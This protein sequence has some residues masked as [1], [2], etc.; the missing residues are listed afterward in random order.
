MQGMQNHK[1]KRE[2]QEMEEKIH[3]FVRRQVDLLVEL[4][5]VWGTQIKGTREARSSITKGD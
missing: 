5:T 2:V 4:S 1:L 3:E